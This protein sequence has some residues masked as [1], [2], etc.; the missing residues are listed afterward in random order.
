MEVDELEGLSLDEELDLSNDDLVLD[1]I[2]EDSTVVSSEVAE[3]NEL[4]E[5]SSE[6]DIASED[7]TDLEEELDLENALDFGEDINI[8]SEI[9]NA[10]SELSQEDLDRELDNETLL[11][12]VTNEIDNIDL[13]NARDLQMAIG[14]IPTE[15]LNESS[16]SSKV[17]ELE[18]LSLENDVELENKTEQENEIDLEIEPNN[19]GIES[20]KNLL[21]ALTNENVVASM[22]GMKIS[23]NIELG[24]NK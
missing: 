23:I 12:I 5:L 16:E 15:P 7:N 6:T 4:E 8:E 3:V 22:K 24:D 9:E 2:M 17:S 11:D 21:I 10:V 13:L 19:Q 18:E 1:E 14:E 20:L